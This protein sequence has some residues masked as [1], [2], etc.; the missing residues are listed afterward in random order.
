MDANEGKTLR[1]RLFIPTDCYLIGTAGDFTSDRDFLFICRM[2]RQLWK[3][4]RD[5]H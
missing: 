3:K 4:G 2:V 5:I 1:E